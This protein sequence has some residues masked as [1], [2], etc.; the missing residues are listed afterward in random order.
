MNRSVCCFLQFVIHGLRVAH[1]SNDHT[2]HYPFMFVVYLTTRATTK[3][4]I[5]TDIW[6]IVDM[7]YIYIYIYAGVDRPLEAV[8]HTRY[9]FD[10][11]PGQET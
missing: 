9:G 7:L 4:G 11:A 5:V 1:H 10:I 6:T 2:N 3:L 8:A